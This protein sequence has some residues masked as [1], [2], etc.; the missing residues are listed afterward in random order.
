V[1]KIT[2][3]DVQ[4]VVAIH[5]GISKAEM[6]GPQRAKRIARPRQMAMALTRELTHLSLTQIGNRFGARHYTTALNAI[7]VM[8]QRVADS[9]KL[10]ADMALF[11]ELLPLVA[12]EREERERQGVAQ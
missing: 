6:L 10:Q 1:A 4:R 11:R 5:Y 8:P 12:Q 7:R 3:G 2:I 9:A